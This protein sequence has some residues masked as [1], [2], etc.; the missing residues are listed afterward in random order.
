MLD[1][2]NYMPTALTPIVHHFL[3]NICRNIVQ[4]GK[5]CA[6]R[7]CSVLFCGGCVTGK[8][9]GWKC[10]VCQERGC[11][12]DMHRK[13]KDFI[14]LLKFNCPG[15]SKNMNYESMLK[16]VETC[17]EAMKVQKEGRGG[18]NEEFKPID[19]A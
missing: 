6:R 1:Q 16:H 3:C 13:L 4:D 2:E 18:D 7:A 10:P 19:H 17:E 12:I 8:Q 9:A 14:T 11:P 5:Q 15:C